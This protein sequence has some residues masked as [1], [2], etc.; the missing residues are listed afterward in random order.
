MVNEGA[1]VTGPKPISSPSLSDDQS[2]F[3]SI[4]DELWGTVT[5][6]GS[7]GKIIAGETI[8]QV[9]AQM[10]IAPDFKYT[11]PV[12]NTEL[13]FVHRKLK[14][15]D[16]YWVNNRNDRYE[17]LSG[18]FRV[19]GK[20]PELWDPETGKISASSYEI[21]NGH[22]IIPMHL[23]P[24]DAIF[25]VFRR[26]TSKTSVD[27]PISVEKE[28]AVI[29]GPW[30]IRFQP[31]RGAPAEITL[32]ELAPWN[33][34]ADN[35]IKYFSGSGTYTKSI[36]VPDEWIQPGTS[37]ILD[38]GVVKN[39]AEVII[40]GKSLGIVWKTPFRVDVTKAL[41]KG[42]NKLVIKVTNLWVNRLIGDQ[43]PGVTKKITYTTMDFYRADSPLL[44]SGLLGPVQII[45]SSK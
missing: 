6:T 30:N 18:T 41:K 27:L 37:L 29:E 40:N 32:D 34:N 26:N 21:E 23:K 24:N 5:G 33:E 19:E 13:L 28:L 45:R 43:Q 2:E 36:E 16:I 38:L 12:D 14:D 15:A 3:K 25:V 11:K 9:L 39:L 1:V 31:G 20:T 44:P 4:A 42:E 22:T 35:G 7:K 17:D 10:N 8:E